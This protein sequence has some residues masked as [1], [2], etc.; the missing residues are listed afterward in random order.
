MKFI[1]E[2]KKYFTSERSERM[3]SFFLEKIN[4]ICLSQQVIFFLLH[5]YVCFK[6]KKETRQKIK[7]KQRNDVSDIFTSEDMENTSRIPDVVSYGKYELSSNQRVIFFL[8]HR[9]ECFENKKTRRK[10]KEKQRNDVSDIFTSEDMKTL[11]LVSR[12]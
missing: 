5:R 7:E 4:F 8:L 9:Y 2:W 12:M 6:K 3:K 11:S 1:F 10:T